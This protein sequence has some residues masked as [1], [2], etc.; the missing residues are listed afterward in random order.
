M[1]RKVMYVP[2]TTVAKLFASVKRNGMQ[3][4]Q[5]ET[6]AQCLQQLPSE[7]QMRTTASELQSLLVSGRKKEAL[8]CAQEGQLWGPALVLAAQLADQDDQG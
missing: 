3:L 1:Q 4:N 8:Q 2:E 7:G 5:Y 6:V